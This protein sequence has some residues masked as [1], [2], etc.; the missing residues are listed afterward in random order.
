MMR[1]V[2]FTIDDL[3]Y[4]KRK[5]SFTDRQ[6]DEFFGDSESFMAIYTLVGEGNHPDK[7]ELTDY[8]GNKISLEALNGYQKGIILNQC[9]EY[10]TNGK[11]L[12]TQPELHGV[13]KIDE[14][15]V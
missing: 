10:F 13:I 12:R 7:Y 14:M 4:F 3:E 11:S 9:M 2:T 8:N 1:K 6:M 5:F 15:E